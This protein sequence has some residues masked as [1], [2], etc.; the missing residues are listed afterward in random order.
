[1]SVSVRLPAL[2]ADRIDG[3]SRVEVSG[4]NVTD[5]LQ[6]LAERHP[7]LQTLILRP[8]GALNPVMV[9][10]LNEVQ[11]TPDKLDSPL[12]GGDTLEIIPAIEGG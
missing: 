12:K 4:R 9:V 11:L 1:M 7:A 3:V 5:A 6:A 8:D 10:F 2:F